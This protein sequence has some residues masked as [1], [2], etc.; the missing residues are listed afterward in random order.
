MKSLWCFFA[1]I[2]LAAVSFTGCKGDRYEVTDQQLI[3]KQWRLDYIED[4]S[5]GEKEYYPLSSLSYTLNF[6]SDG[7]TEFPYHCNL[8]HAEY[9]LDKNGTI[10][11]RVGSMTELYCNFISEWESKLVS[12][13]NEAKT[14]KILRNMLIISCSDGRNVA[15]S[16]QT[17]DMSDLGIEL[18]MAEAA[19]SLYFIC[20]TK[21]IYPC[22]SYPILYIFSQVD[23]EIFIHFGGVKKTD[24]CHTALSP[25]NVYINAGKLA[26][27]TYNLNISYLD[28][29]FSGRLT[30]SAMEY[31]VV[32]INNDADIEVVNNV[33]NRSAAF[34]EYV[35]QGKIEDT[36]FIINSLLG[37]MDPEFI[38]NTVIDS[39]MRWLNNRS[40]VTETQ[41]ICL[42]CIKTTP[43]HSA[44]KVSFLQQND[45][46]YYLMDVSM[47][48]PAEITGIHKITEQSDVRLIEKQWHFKSV[49]NADKSDVFL[50]PEDEYDDPYFMQFNISG[51]VDFPNFCNMPGSDYLLCEDGRIM[52]YG[53]IYR[54][55][56]TICPWFPTEFETTVSEIFM[57]SGTYTIS[58]DGARLTVTSLDREKTVTCQSQ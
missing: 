9:S 37:S 26:A 5:T 56:R 15:F 55:R 46:V 43:A 27:G 20:Q 3:G 21:K 33:F 14:Y 47:G 8:S 1:A 35:S 19:D 13:L 57:K 51:R 39:L 28:K 4:A 32:V 42:S 52:F 34:D 40:T 38:D 30:V 29:T 54:Q 22:A 18:R 23:N 6:N 53:N 7:T 50:Y 45:T 36:K 49:S 58:E 16:S 12:L 10:T 17:A 25:A 11:F 48:V 31:E 2:G 41:R 44:L 24:E